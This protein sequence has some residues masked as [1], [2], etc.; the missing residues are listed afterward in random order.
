MAPD[1][2]AICRQWQTA[3][4]GISTRFCRQRCKYSG[5]KEAT[6]GERAQP[7]TRG[8]PIPFRRR[9]YMARAIRSRNASGASSNISSA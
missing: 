2:A 8:H 9:T 5:Q 3:R 4:N 1:N 6:P 7:Q